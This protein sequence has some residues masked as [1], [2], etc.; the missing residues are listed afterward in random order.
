MLFCHQRFLRQQIRIHFISLEF[1]DGNQKENREEN[2]VILESIF[3]RDISGDHKDREQRPSREN[4]ISM[5]GFEIN[6]ENDDRD[7]SE[8][9][10]I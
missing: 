2:R 8:E 3:S 10:L 7:V 5:H 1:Q 6:R 9:R 4:H